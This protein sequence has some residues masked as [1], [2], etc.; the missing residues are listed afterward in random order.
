MSFFGEL[1][2]LFAGLLNLKFWVAGR[3][4]STISPF[5]VRDLYQFSRL[6][7]SSIKLDGPM[8]VHQRQNCLYFKNVFN[9]DN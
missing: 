4:T 1:S 9:A 3:S 2:I 5:L 8:D 6:W 7:F